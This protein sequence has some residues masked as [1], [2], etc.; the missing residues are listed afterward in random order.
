M[1]NFIS[2]LCMGLLALYLAFR[3]ILRESVIYFTSGYPEI[4]KR[5]GNISPLLEFFFFMIIAAGFFAGGYISYISI[6]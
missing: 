2:S 1:G 6:K 3:P 4:R 5:L